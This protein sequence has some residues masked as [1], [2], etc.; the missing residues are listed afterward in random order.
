MV[1]VA[2]GSPL[3][4]GL[5]RILYAAMIVVLVATARTNRLAVDA[6]GVPVGAV[7]V[8]RSGRPS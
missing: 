1:V 6:T 2:P 5:G 8:A 4:G 3:R 7:V